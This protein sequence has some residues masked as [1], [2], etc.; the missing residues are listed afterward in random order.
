MLAPACAPNEPGESVQVTLTPAILRE[1][2]IFTPLSIQEQ[3]GDD[4]DVAESDENVRE[5]ELLVLVH[6]RV[7]RPEQ[8]HH[9]EHDPGREREPLAALGR[10][11]LYDLRQEGDRREES[12]AG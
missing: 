3:A 4:G 8:V 10:V 2:A 9:G 11:D 1:Y 7:E 5:E 12:D 6:T